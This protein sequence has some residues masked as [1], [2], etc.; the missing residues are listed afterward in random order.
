MAVMV[1]DHAAIGMTGGPLLGEGNDD[2][3]RRMIARHMGNVQIAQSVQNAAEQIRR[4]HKQRQH[5]AQ[6]ARQSEQEV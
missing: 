5:T 4:E 3:A 2:I 1:S 6:M